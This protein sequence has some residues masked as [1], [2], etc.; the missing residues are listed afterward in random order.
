MYGTDDP[1]A[2][3]YVRASPVTHV[4]KNAPPVLILHGQID[5]TVDR[6]QSEELAGVLAKHGV[7]HEFV[8]V[9]GAGHTFDF[10]TWNKQPLS[11]DLRPVA[12]AFLEKHLSL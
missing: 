1:A 10:E 6:A 12:L 11:R 4:T 7:P 5:L 2:P 9:A 8:R 3:V